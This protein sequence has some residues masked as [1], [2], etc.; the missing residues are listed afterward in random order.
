MNYY[1]SNLHLLHRNVT[2]A[3]NNFDDRPFDN[4]KEMHSIIKE[5]WNTKVTH[6]DM[7][8]ILWDI[9]MHGRQ[10]ELI[11][12]VSM[13]KGNKILVRGNHDDIRNLRYKQGRVTC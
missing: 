5:K 13:F 12:F 11:A 9:A 4:L 3:G 10:E 6:D 2:R 8:Y 1:I 7:V